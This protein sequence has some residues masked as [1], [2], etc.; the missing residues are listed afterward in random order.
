MLNNKG[1]LF[2][3]NSIDGKIYGK[4]IFKDLENTIIVTP[5]L[6]AAKNVFGVKEENITLYA[7]NGSNILLAING[8]NGKLF[9]KRKEI[10]HLEEELHLS[11]FHICK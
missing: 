8:D 5:A 11:K 10:Y 7:H 2:K 1:Y 9:G 4:Q 3:I 6:S